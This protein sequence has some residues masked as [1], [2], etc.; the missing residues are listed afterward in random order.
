MQGHEFFAP[1][2]GCMRFWVSKTLVSAKGIGLIN[3]KGLQT[4][5]HAVGLT[6][7]PVQN[8]ET[9]QISDL[10]LNGQR[11]DCYPLLQTWAW[12]RLIFININR[13]S[14]I[15][16]RKKR[17]GHIIKAFWKLR[18]QIGCTS[19]TNKR[20]LVVSKP[21]IAFTQI[22]IQ[23]YFFGIALQSL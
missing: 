12:A 10:P 5:L 3:Y 21:P 18:I 20:C 2:N 15:P 1:E 19:K 13:G 14:G 11:P 17:I 4:P 22:I 16:E 6:A 23:V 7:T 9:P 8:C